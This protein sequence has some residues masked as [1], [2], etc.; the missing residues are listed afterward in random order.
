MATSESEDFESADEE[1]D[2]EDSCKKKPDTKV[3]KPYEQKSSH[4]EPQPQPI[5]ED[6]PVSDSAWEPEDLDDDILDSIND[7]LDEEEPV[8]EINESVKD[9]SIA[10]EPCPVAEPESIKSEET[11]ARPGVESESKNLDAVKV[12]PLEPESKGSRPRRVRESKAISKV[13]SEGSKKLGSKLAT[14]VSESMKPED[15]ET[16]N[17]IAEQ[18]KSRSNFVEKPA[19]SCNEELEIL[20]KKPDDVNQCLDKEPDRP[21]VS[22]VFDKLSSTLE[23]QPEESSVTILYG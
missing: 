8:T 20:P 9:L 10:D 4:P 16:K 17:T 22:S 12:L 2:G 15:D 3:D 7:K 14:P 1:F 5:Q 19:R 13:A 11:L 6:E 23:Q 21:A 18:L